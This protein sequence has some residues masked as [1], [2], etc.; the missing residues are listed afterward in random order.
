MNEW[1][2]IPRPREEEWFDR[3]VHGEEDVPGTLNG[4]NVLNPARPE[5]TK[6]ARDAVRC[7][8]RGEVKIADLTGRVEN[9]S[10]DPTIRGIAPQVQLRH[11]TNGPGEGSPQTGIFH[12]RVLGEWFGP[13][14]EVDP[15]N[16]PAG[17]IVMFDR[18]DI[19]RH[20]K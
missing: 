13:D 3:I 14:D 18:R 4:R 11:Y 17:A 7:I 5:L 12:E 19:Q 1:F 2:D 20:W 8:L 9:I 15:A 10:D 16:D 6:E